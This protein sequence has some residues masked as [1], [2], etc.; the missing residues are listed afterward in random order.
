MTT[1]NVKNQRMQDITRSI[2]QV[3]NQFRAEIDDAVGVS[4]VL[5][6]DYL[7][8]DILEDS[9]EH[10]A[11]YIYAYDSY[12]RRILNNYTPT[13]QAVQNITV[14]VDSTSIMPSGGNIYYIDDIVHTEWYEELTSKNIKSPFLIRTERMNVLSVSDVM[15]KDVFSV[16]RVLDYFRMDNS[17][18]KILKIDLRTESIRQIFN[19][20]NLVG[21]VYLLNP[22]GRIEYTTNTDIDWESTERYYTGVQ[23]KYD[24]IEFKEN[25][26]HVSYLDG[27]S[28]VAVISDN[29]VF[30][31][32]KKSRS[33]VLYLTGLIIIFPTII[34]IWMVRSLNTRIIRILKHMKKVRNQNFEIIDEP[35]THDEIGQLTSEFN[36]MTMQIKR[37]IDDVYVA[38]IRGKDLEIQRRHAQLQALQ[39]QINPHFFFNS[40]ETIRMRSLIKNEKE[41]ARIIQNMAKILRNSLTFKKDFITVKEELELIECF[42]EIQKYRFGDKLNYTIDVENDAMDCHIPQM[43]LLPF[44]ENA[45]IHGLEAV[46]AGGEISIRIQREDNAIILEVQDNGKGIDAL[47]LQRLKGFLYRE[48]EMGDRVGVQNVIYRLKLFYQKRFKFNISSKLDEGTLI[49][50]ELPLDNIDP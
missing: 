42:L 50:L 32:V 24:T 47:T 30:E 43:S 13:Y 7:L 31:E 21:D 40:L 4:S 14:Y 9:Y 49:Y 25:F 8:N 19:N 26:P 20:L 35:E 33:F 34:I 44:V 11:D 48:E 22:D 12:I 2:E 10:P 36:R 5:Y 3:S 39:S 38:D 46:K 23:N 17:V 29:E 1:E 18:K 41:T 16:I 37:L 45:S 6:T 15:Q 28:V 27:W